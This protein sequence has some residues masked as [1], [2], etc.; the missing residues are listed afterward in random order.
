MTDF[1][2]MTTHGRSQDTLH[3]PFGD[4]YLKPAFE[5]LESDVGNSYKMNDVVVKPL[6]TP[7]LRDIFHSIGTKLSPNGGVLSEST[8]LDEDII[9]ELNENDAGDV[10]ES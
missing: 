5:G 9:I 10:D 4:D 2:T 1:K 3:K 8:E 7:E 6:V